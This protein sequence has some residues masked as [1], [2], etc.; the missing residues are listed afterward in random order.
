MDLFADIN[1]HALFLPDTP[2]LEIFIRGSVVYLTLFFFLRTI[3]KRQAGTLG[4]T[5]L[6]VIV[7][8]AD[9]SQNAMAADYKSLPD[10][11]LLVATLI[12]WN[13]TLEWL[14]F[15]SRLAERIITPA[16]LLLIRNGRMLRRNM[17]KEFITEDELMSQLRLQGVDD[18]TRVKQACLEGD[19][20]ISIVEKPQRQHK[21]RGSSS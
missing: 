18:I 10:G 16:P 9:A 14:G 6:L 19:G 15:H 21:P 17:K 7:L 4:M 13:Y 3:L 1:W 11:I 5:D 2:P 8:I 12:F 20:K